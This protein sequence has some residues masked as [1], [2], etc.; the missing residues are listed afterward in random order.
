MAMTLGAAV[1]T[2]LR[3]IGEAAIA[4]FTTTNQLQ[5][6]LIAAA[7]E[8]VHD[9][10]EAV[11]YRWGT[12]HDAFATVL[13]ITTDTVAMTHD[14]TTV[15]S[16]GDNF[17]GVAAGDYIRF[18]SELASYEIASV[19]T[20]TSPDTLVLSDAYIVTTDTDATY[21][22]LRDTYAVSVTDLDEIAIASYGEGTWRGNRL[23]V[24]DMRRLIDVAEGD[25]HRNDSG[26]PRYIARISPNSSDVPRFVLWPYPDAEYLIDI[27]HTKKFNVTTSD[28]ATSLFGGDAPDLATDA[29][30]HYLR[31][32]ACVYDNDTRQA[33]A[34]MQMYQDFRKKIVGREARMHLDDSQMSIN[35]YRRR[36]TPR[37]IVG[38]SQIEFDRE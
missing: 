26:Y 28:V 24:V 13:P 22:I 33:Q 12:F 4:A 23:R 21:T 6:E 10:L 30:C 7:N 19:V 3:T 20:A 31:W 25:L 5:V 15:T 14:S 38:V 1:N 36:R 35:T 8:A 17:T 16:S 9:V 27:W 29:V 32:R 34:W 18:G 2:G 37:G 11:R